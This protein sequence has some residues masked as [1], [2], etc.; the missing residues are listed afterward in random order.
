MDCAAAA[1]ATAAASGC[2]GLERRLPRDHP[3]GCAGASGSSGGRNDAADATHMDDVAAHCICCAAL[4]IV[5]PTQAASIS[6]VGTPTTCAITDNANVTPSPNACTLPAQEGGA[7]AGGGSAWTNSSSPTNTLKGTLE[8]IHDSRTAAA[9]ASH[10]LITVPTPVSAVTVTRTPTAGTTAPNT[11]AAKTDGPSC[12]RAPSIFPSTASCGSSNSQ[13]AASLQNICA[14]RSTS[15][16]ITSKPPCPPT[17]CRS[18]TC[19]YL[20]AP[21]ADIAS[22]ACV[23]RGTTTSLTWRSTAATRR[24]TAPAI[25]THGDDGEAE[26]EGGAA[27]G[28]GGAL[29]P[30]PLA[31]PPLPLPPPP[32]PTD[33]AVAPCDTPVC[34]VS[35]CSTL[36]TALQCS[37]V[38]KPTHASAAARGTRRCLAMASRS[39]PPPRTRT[40]VRLAMSSRN[41]LATS[42][43]RLRTHHAHTRAAADAG[44]SA[45]GLGRQEAAAASTSATQAAASRGAADASKQVSSEEKMFSAAERRAASVAAAAA[46]AT[47]YRT[48]HTRS[49]DG[50]ATAHTLEARP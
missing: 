35:A 20:A 14:P 7:S 6:S 32:P 33:V 47:S 37:L 4:A 45:S 27:A 28:A 31:F 8:R 1:A 44:A 3:W 40:S 13:T 15:E 46:A 48:P 49:A 5:S 26:A 50:M 12:A 29:A 39:H 34:C 18:G 2:A 41:D 16:R 23:R 42:V 17:R 25:G 19:E 36:S 30:V 38:T 21:H 43:E 22:R 10:S 9:L 11:A 24:S